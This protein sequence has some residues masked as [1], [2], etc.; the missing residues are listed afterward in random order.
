MRLSHGYGDT[1]PVPALLVPAGVDMDTETLLVPT[2]G[3][4]AGARVTIW[5]GPPRLARLGIRVTVSPDVAR[6]SLRPD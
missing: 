6:F 3:F 5:E 1:L 4:R 2:A